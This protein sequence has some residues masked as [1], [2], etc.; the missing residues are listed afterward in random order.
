MDASGETK[1]M[2]FQILEQ[3]LC[4]VEVLCVPLRVLQMI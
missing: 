1:E 3:G 4:C 2:V